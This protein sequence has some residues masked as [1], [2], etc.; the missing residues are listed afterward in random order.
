ME[1]VGGGEHLGGDRRVDD[2]GQRGEG[3]GG[4]H[5]GDLDAL[6]G[7]PR[8]HGDG[9]RGPSSTWTVV[10]EVY[11]RTDAPA[12]HDLLGAPLPH[13]ARAV[14]GV[15][16][17]LD[18]AGDLLGLVTALAGQR[19]R[20]GSHTAFHSDIPLIRWAPQSAEIS[21]RTRPR[22]SRCRS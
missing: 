1:V 2:P 18:Q 14:L 7:S 13:H 6:V 4:D 8:R 15:L 10:A 16:E 11:I 22:P 9:H 12:V 3:H 17:L 19:G 5:V 21:R 20:I